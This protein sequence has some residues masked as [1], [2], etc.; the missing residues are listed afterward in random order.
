MTIK[1]IAMDSFDFA[2]IPKDMEPGLFATAV[3]HAP[4]ANYPNGCHICELEIDHDTGKVE[5]VRYT[6]VDDVGTVLNPDAAARPDPRRRR[7]GRRPGA[8]GRHPFRRRAAS[9]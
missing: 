2:K 8:D 7:A 4:V 6:V 5:I 1:E 3:Y 9:S